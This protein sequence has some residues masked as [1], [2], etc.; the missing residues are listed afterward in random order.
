MSEPSRDRSPVLFALARVSLLWERIW[1]QLWPLAGVLG[2][3]LALALSDLLPRMPGWLHALVLLGILA[4]LFFAGRHVWRSVKPITENDVLHKIELDNALKHR[5]LTAVEDRLAA[6]SQDPAAVEM[7]ELHRRRMADL[8]KK[9]IVKAPHPG[10]PRRDPN[11]VRAAVLLVLVVAVVAGWK[12]PVGRIERAVLPQLGDP[13]KPITLDVWVTPP[14]YTRVA[15]MFLDRNAQ[16]AA[17]PLRIPAGSALLAQVAGSLVAPIL[18][19]GEQAIAF[20]EIG[21]GDH[22]VETA[23]EKGNRLTVEHDGSVLASWPLEVVADM[24]PSVAFQR[25]PTATRRKTTRIDYS[26]R[27]DYGLA[28]VTAEVRRVGDKRGENAKPGIVLNLPLPGVAPAKAKGNVVRNLTAHPWAG[29]EVSI[30]LIA[31]DVAG[32][33]GTTEDAVMTLPEREF[34]NPIARLIIS[35]RK[36]LVEPTDEVID[37]V[38]KALDRLL[39][40]PE[41]YSNDT[42]VHLSLKVARERIQGKTDKEED[43]K[44][45]SSAQ[46]LMWDTAIRLEEKQAE[47]ARRQLEKMQDKVRQA[48]RDKTKDP[49]LDKMMEELKRALDKYMEAMEKELERLEFF[50]RELPPNAQMLTQEDLKKMLEKAQELAMKGDRKGAEEMMAQLKEMLK[51]LEQQMAQ[52]NP[53]SA[54]GRAAAKARAKAQKAIHGLR[55]LIKKQQALI[56]KTYRLDKKIDSP[57]RGQRGGVAEAIQQEQL[58]RKLGDK[59]LEFHEAFGGIPGNMGEAERSMRDSA[60]SLIT[61]NLGQGTYQQAEAL[62]EMRRSANSAQQQMQGQPGGMMVGRGPGRGPGN[63]FGRF[64]PRDGRDR[65]GFPRPGRDRDPFG[66]DNE[67]V[68]NSGDNVDG[69]VEIPDQMDAKRAKEILEEL[70]RRSADRRRSPAELDYIDRLLKQF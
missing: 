64:G 69:P 60:E 42:V 13:A 20:D 61:G 21:P 43:E 30:R 58:R 14:A 55:E 4:A 66:R 70:R 67:N 62:K 36:L 45:I 23:I 35:N 26:A 15:P 48:L 38:T 11:A 3:F 22:R 31:T 56:N 1:P 2:M 52:S 33:T 37:T 32:L 47:L 59:M 40:S 12:D 6:G 27:D 57:P 17:E 9:L 29:F 39:A 51:Q 34:N 18:T 68:R 46:Q 54:A 19:L 7:W 65:R 24:P 5:P 41:L 49:A 8:A 53:N 25:P 50:N 10:V 28:T 44:D 16:Q 63:R